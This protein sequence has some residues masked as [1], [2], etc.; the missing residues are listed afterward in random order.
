MK[1][2]LLLI[3]STLFA[4]ITIS[5]HSFSQNLTPDS[6]GTIY[7]KVDGTG[8][9][10]SW[11]NATSDLQ[12][13]ID[14]YGVTQVW[15]SKGTYYATKLLP[16]NEVNFRMRAFQMKGGVNV[17]GNFNG[18]ETS[19][20]ERSRIDTSM[21]GAENSV[22]TTNSISYHIVVSDTREHPY[23]AILDG[24]EIRGGKADYI[25]NPPHN[26]GG[27]IV[28]TKRTKVQNCYI[29]SNQAEIGAGA[30]LYQGGT[31]DSCYF[32]NN[33]ASHEGGAIVVIEGGTI[34]N[35]YIFNNTTSG[36]GAG[37]YMEDGGSGVIKNCKIIGNRADNYGG[38]VYFR[39]VESANIQGSYIANNIASISGGGI[40]VYNSSAD[41]YS[42]TVVNNEATSGYGGGINSYNNA[43]AN[44]VNS[45]FI[46]NTASTGNNMHQ[47]NAGCTLNVS[48]S[49][50]EGGYE[51]ENNVSISSNDFVDSDYDDL[52]DGVD[53]VSAPSKCLNSGDNSI[54]DASDL[55]LNGNT[56]IAFGIVDMGA[57]E[58][59]TCI[60]YQLTSSVSS[61]G[62]SISPASVT[63]AHGSSQIFTLA[64][65]EGYE[66][67]EATFSGSGTVV[68]NTD[69][70]LT[71]GGVTSAGQ[72]S[73]A[74]KLKQYEITTST[75]IGGGISPASVTLAHGSSQTFTLAI[76]EGYELD[77]A[78]FSGSGTV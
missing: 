32:M 22:L 1:H 30:V 71:L 31:I 18:N 47:C 54:V 26:F 51:G 34:E 40:Y 43:S 27:G 25:V 74:F 5:L 63:L 59:I 35:S 76:D 11:E 42:C 52:Y 6:T 23:G 56:R 37:I 58:S 75:S 48:Y 24:F 9:G 78:T 2:F 33:S 61:E 55:D 41:I 49:G 14:V 57:F 10:S 13:A 28:L 68:N 50:I 15:V 65:D 4:L 66:L 7:V 19:I 67:D 73:V 44:I 16:T 39:N 60:T 29:H 70:T 36:R 62:G 46:G 8:N 64:I 72:L 38:G 69:G 21:V 17:Y 53:E 12:G 45:V 3:T 20:D 77:E